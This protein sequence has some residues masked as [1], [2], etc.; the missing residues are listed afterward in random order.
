M[1]KADDVKAIVEDVYEVPDLFCK[2][3]PGFRAAVNAIV[4]QISNPL[5]SLG[6]NILRSALNGLHKAK[7][8][9]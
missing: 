8:K 4:K 3:W 2:G 9:A 6:W 5:V 1:L 7:C